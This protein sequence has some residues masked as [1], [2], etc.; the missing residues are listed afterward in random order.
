MKKLIILTRLLIILPVFF[1]ATAVMTQNITNTVGINGTFT[2]KDA[3][4]NFLTVTQS[5]G[6]VNILNTLKI[7]NTSSLGTG[8]LYI[9]GSRFMHNIGGSNM[10][11]G[12][13]AGN[14]TMTGQFNTGV[15]GGALLSLTSG[16][17]NSALGY[18]SL[19][20]NT[21][22]RENTACGF[23]A[24]RFNT[25]GNYNSAFGSLSMRNNTTGSY[26][27]AFG[28]QSMLNNTTGIEN[29]AFGLL[30]LTTNT[31]GNWNSAFG[32]ES[33][34]KSTMNFNTAIGK[35]SGSNITTGSGVVCIGYNSQPSS[36]NAIN[37]L[38][39]GNNSITS[40]RC[41]VTTITSLSDV[42]DKKNIKDLSLGL[43]FLMKIK[44][45]LFNWDKRE[46]YENNV[47]D[48]TK[49]QEIPTAGF[50][51][52]ELDEAQTSENAEWLNLV[53]KD[54]PE[55]FEAM[56]GN[57]L[58]V[59]IKALQELKSEN[60]RLK[61]TNAELKNKNKGYDEHLL[62]LKELQ[63]LMAFEIEKMKSKKNADELHNVSNIKGENLK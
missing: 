39:L 44:P 50:I 6:Q 34:L 41:A 15:G 40:L 48:G 16:S 55:K 21:S 30:A 23:G 14:L 36:G 60:E 38:T 61:N 12:E 2:V 4:F 46:W 17:Y 51:A 28:Y 57:L 25:T 54:N 9:G 33:L 26:N 52:Q 45:R 32:C 37:E 59:I 1:L 53:L 63:E 10:F 13:I 62:K 56:A 49:I 35:S 42:R 47:S 24:L 11:L 29:S 43:S 19:A 27:S 3:N 31:G 7:E 58:P 18:G 8:V 20:A 22:G 5:T